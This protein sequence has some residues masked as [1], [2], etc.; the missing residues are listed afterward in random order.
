MADGDKRTLHISGL[1]PW[2]SEVQLLDMIP[3]DLVASVA[4]DVKGVSVVLD[5]HTNLCRG[6]GFIA[7]TD[8][9]AAELLLQWINDSRLTFGEEPIREPSAQLEELDDDCMDD[10]VMA[11]SEDGRVAARGSPTSANDE[12]QYVLVATL[13]ARASAA[14]KD[15]AASRPPPSQ[16]AKQRHADKVPCVPDAAALRAFLARMVR[17]RMQR[18]GSSKAGPPLWESRSAAKSRPKPQS[19]SAKKGSGNRGFVSTRE[20]EPHAGSTNYSALIRSGLLGVSS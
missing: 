9:R 8:N 13:A 10:E 6:F 14:R 5:R 2:F 20:T 18:S 12:G 15:K 11:V 16:D 7:C 17:V 4:V 1:P 19:C 3:F